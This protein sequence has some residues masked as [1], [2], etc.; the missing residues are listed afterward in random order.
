MLIESKSIRTEYIKVYKLAD[1]KIAIPIFQRFYS[2]NEKHIA[3]LIADL[4]ECL[5]DRK[6]IFLLDFICYEEDDVIKLADGQQRL[7]TLNLLIKVINE[8]TDS[9]LYTVE[10]FDIFYDNV[11]N[12]KK[13]QQAINNY[14]CAPFK[15][16]Y[17]RLTDFVKEH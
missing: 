10:P 5:Y 16:V 12:N 13:Y 11:E 14:M 9:R 6:D 15:K 2:W 1:K 17:I 3:P 7:V 4:T 8:H